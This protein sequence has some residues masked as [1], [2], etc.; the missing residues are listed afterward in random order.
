MELT[1][2]KPAASTLSFYYHNDI[3]LVYILLLIKDFWKPLFPVLLSLLL[4]WI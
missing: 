3:L 4:Q 2:L 1:Q